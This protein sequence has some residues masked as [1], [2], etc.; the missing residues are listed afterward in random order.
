M[1]RKEPR[2]ATRTDLAVMIVLFCVILT[3]YITLRPVFSGIGD[4][5]LGL[6]A[7]LLYLALLGLW[8]AFR[9]RTVGITAREAIDTIFETE[10]VS[11]LEE[12][13]HPVLLVDEVGHAVFCN[14]AFLT[15]SD[16]EIV[17]RKSVV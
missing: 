5:F 12:M 16:R 14:R 3:L 7:I 4:L 11:A 8:A 6:V 9:I 17:D 15:L 1:R 2:I 13:A 10:L